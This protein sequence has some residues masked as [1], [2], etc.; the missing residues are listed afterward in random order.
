VTGLQFA[1]IFGGIFAIASILMAI[2][3]IL[4]RLLN[5]VNDLR[6]EHRQ[7]TGVMP[8]GMMRAREESEMHR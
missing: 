3:K 7:A 4:E 1:L 6:I 8:A 2:Q 5:A